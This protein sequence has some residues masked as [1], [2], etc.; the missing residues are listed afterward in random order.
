MT[1]VSTTTT[2]AGE[3]TLGGLPELLARRAQKAGGTVALRVKRLG[4]W[5]E[6]TW[7]EYAR[8]AA[9][10]GLGLRALG[11]DAGE[12]V[13]ILCGNQPEWLFV[14]VG[15][16]GVGAAV[17][18]LHP[19]TPPGDAARL[20]HHVG[21][22]AL[23][24]A[25][26]EQL[27]VA[28]AIRADVPSLRTI[29]V[30]DTRGVPSLRAGAEVSLDELEALGGGSRDGAD[31]VV[32]AWA[33]TSARV[34]DS[35]TARIVFSAGSDPPRA[36]AL[37]RTNL[38]ATGVAL[39]DV[40]ALGPGDETLSSLPLSYVGAAVV[41]GPLALR[42]GLVV[43]FGEG[44]ET[45][46]EDAREVQPTLFVA[47]PRWWEEVRSTIELRMARADAVKRAAFRFFRTRGAS[48][49]RAGRPVGRIG[50]ALV[51]R[52]VRA[53]FGL[54]RARVALS[55]G[56]P[57]APAVVES[58]AAL[59]VAL[60]ECYGT[61]ETTGFATCPRTVPVRPGTAGPPLPGMHVRVA[62][63]G[64]V[65]VHG[66]GVFTGYVGDD[67]RTRE[68]I[69]AG[70]WFHTG[71]LGRLDDDGNLVIT[72]R[73]KDVVVTA[74]GAAI[75]PRFLE[76]RLMRSPYVQQ[77]VVVGDGRPYVTALVALAPDVVTAWA[78]EHSVPFTTFQDLARSVEV[79]DLLRG[80]LDDVN[81]DVAPP[82]EIRDVRA[83][84]EP[85]EQSAG[86]L[87]TTQ[88]VRREAVIS[89]NAQLVEE[90]YGS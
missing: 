50:T 31:D 17:A 51:Y 2:A 41:A 39:G 47:V 38:V 15:A 37:S 21:A 26:E 43:N 82:E 70:G 28:R 25:D 40:L 48:R 7:A 6:T 74:S 34:A 56:A 54:R 61:V 18:G 32:R 62:D 42:T 90:M 71:D 85:L 84:P 86:A 66:A 27:D 79:Q 52:P 73:K 5:H 89:A 29:V 10:A 14:E 64:E 11:V 33:E 60:R 1:P 87:T 65:L 78:L 24:V 8:R 46:V 13:A 83:L 81:R 69:D 63:D 36:V 80:V 53:K 75:A 45:L 67:E 4:Y 68:A 16:Q 49:A 30:V 35:A 9:A 3:E 72:D 55:V 19:A 59:G 22:V 77:A 12:T 58:F 57:L 76:E 20:L 44:R 88:R 23:V